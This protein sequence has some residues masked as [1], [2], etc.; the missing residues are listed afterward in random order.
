[1]IHPKKLVLLLFILSFFNPM[2]GTLV[3]PA[4][5]FIAQDLHLSSSEASWI[6]IG[7]EVMLIAGSV[8]YGKLAQ[9]IKLRSLFTASIAMA[10]A[11][12]ILAIFSSNLLSLVLARMLQGAALSAPI[13]LAMIIINQYLPREER[14]KALTYIALA[15]TLGT[16]ISPIIGGIA[17]SLFGWK[18]IFALIALVVIFLPFVRLIPDS[19][20]E[21]AAFPFAAS[22][23][24]IAAFLLTLYGL[25]GHYQF[26]F[27]SIAA[28]GLFFAV[29]HKQA[30]LVDITAFRNKTVAIISALNLLLMLVINSLFF[31]TPIFLE[32]L[33]DLSSIEIGLILLP[34]AI[35]SIVSVKFIGKAASKIGAGKM[36]PLSIGVLG[37]GVAVLLLGIGNSVVLVSFAFLFIYVGFGTFNS[38]L[39]NFTSVELPKKIMVEGIGL[40]NL[41]FFTG[42]TF[43]P[44]IMGIFVDS[45]AVLATPSFTFSTYHLALIGMA[46]ILLGM[47]LLVIRL[48]RTAQKV[49]ESRGAA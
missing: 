13:P 10:A 33:N 6:F 46:V 18:S 37:V 30:A 11:G 29:N 16:G 12:G 25:H 26:L 31:I 39:S 45:D 40:S 41:F 44:A 7:Y 14:K 1:M 24:L 4:L 2:A 38:E 17:T 28:W 9:S 36:L 32:N 43:G 34:G 48:I 22:G 49:Q 23:L 21:K 35:L 5:P 19:K 8:I 27:A 15:I 42:A 20:V 3:I 47:L